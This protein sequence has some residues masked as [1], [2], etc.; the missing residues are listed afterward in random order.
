VSQSPTGETA[1]DPAKG[2]L[3][4]WEQ[5]AKMIQEGRS[6]S[7]HERKCVFLNVRGPRFADVSAAT[8]L[9]LDD[10]GRGLAICD[11]DHDGDLDLW[12]TNRTGPRVRLLKNDAPSGNH[13]LAIKLVGD[14]DRKCNRDAIGARV[15]VHLAGASPRKLIQTL[16]AGDGFISQST[17]WLHFGL[18]DAERIEKVVVRWPVAGGHVEEFRDFAPDKRYELVQGRGKPQPLAEPQREVVL[19]P[20][21]PKAPTVSE[22]VRIRLSQPLHVPELSYQDLDGKTHKLQEL[23]RGPVLVNLFATWCQPCLAELRDIARRQSEINRWKVQVLALCVDGLGTEG[24][25]QEFDRL[26]TLKLLNNVGFSFPAG[27]ANAALVEALDSLQ[28]SAIYR[29][30][31]LPLPSSFL[32]D[33]A[34]RVVA[35]YKGPV[36]VDQLLADIPTMMELD[37]ARLRDLAIPFPGRWLDEV[38]VSNPLVVGS[39]YLQDGGAKEAHNY[40]D[41]F[42]DRENKPP[43]T[44]SRAQRAQRELRLADLYATLAEAQNAQGRATDAARAAEKA[45]ELNEKLAEAHL[46]R[47][48]ALVEL[49]RPRE[50][51]EA[52]AKARPLAPQDPR[53]GAL[54]GRLFERR[55]DATEAIAA[56]RRSIA[57]RP[58]WSNTASARDALL[59]AKGRAAI[60]SA[61]Q[62]PWMHAIAV[63]RWEAAVR[64]SAGRL[65]WLLATSAADELRSGREAVELAHRAC[66]LSANAGENELDALSAALAEM[67][68]FAKAAKVARQALFW[69][70]A[71]GNPSLAKAIDQRRALYEAGKPYRSR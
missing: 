13:F 8:S 24:G 7:G 38:M 53:I 51:A 2:Y 14:I 11:W 9:D 47:A 70:Q 31:R 39:I 64:H 54:E 56:Y 69:A 60:K 4:A 33:P 20:T 67:G 17:K 52:L 49:D 55:G 62:P 43:A 21:S 16:Y 35:V 37:P 23:I 41:E 57:A 58:D 42:L 36:S 32:I 66:Q 19:T 12:M 34:G 30:P 6:F 5:L 25:G 26:K 3:D 22:T 44:E 1:L 59:A 63:V 68:D 27:A 71:H 10:D 65:A 45:I 29:Q 15:E 61:G 18:G 50:A 28:R 46:Q 40:I 48:A